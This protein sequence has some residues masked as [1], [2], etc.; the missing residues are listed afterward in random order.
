[1]IAILF[2]VELFYYCLSWLLVLE[3]QMDESGHRENGRHKADQYK[4]AQGGPV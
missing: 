2:A 1:M 4:S 3:S